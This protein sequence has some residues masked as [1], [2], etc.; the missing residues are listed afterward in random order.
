MI[1]RICYLWG[2]SKRPLDI[3][4]SHCLNRVEWVAPNIPEEVLTSAE[5]ENILEFGGE[6][7]D[8]EWGEPIE[9]DRVEIDADG[10]TTIITIYNRA[11][12]L[13]ATDSEDVKRLHRFC[14][15]L[16]KVAA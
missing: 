9:V 15:V 8:P 10:Q 12:L 11:I 5:Q 16:Q 3:E 14:F 1:R 13:M 2:M 4:S 6:C 7:G